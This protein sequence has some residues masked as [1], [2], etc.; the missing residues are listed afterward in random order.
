[1]IGIATAL[2]LHSLLLTRV[3]GTADEARKGRLVVAETA[4]VH[5]SNMEIALRPYVPTTACWFVTD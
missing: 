5:V 2:L 1:M 3:F 4:R